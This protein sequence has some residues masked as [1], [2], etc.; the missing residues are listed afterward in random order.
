MSFWLSKTDSA[1]SL[2]TRTLVEFRGNE[3]I[4]E[5]NY[6]SQLMVCFLKYIGPTKIPIRKFTA[7]WPAVNYP[8]PGEIINVVDFLASEATDE[9]DDLLAH[10]K[11]GHGNSFY[12]AL[13][14]I[15]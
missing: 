3:V 14:S 5:G 10:T 12:R 8:A 7:R 13:F 2:E 4:I 6:Q 11:L 15:D 9:A 1:G